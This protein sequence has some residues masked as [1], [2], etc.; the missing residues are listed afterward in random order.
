MTQGTGVSFDLFSGGFTN[1]FF[2]L[3]ELSGSVAMRHSFLSSEITCRNKGTDDG[4]PEPPAFP[5]RRK[6]IRHRS[7]NPLF[8]I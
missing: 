3:P 4:F 2:S 8:F 5:V 7:N 1:Q 6:M